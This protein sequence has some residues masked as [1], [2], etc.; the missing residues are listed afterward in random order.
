MHDPGNTCTLISIYI[1]H[2][3]MTHKKCTGSTQDQIKLIIRRDKYKKSQKQGG[4]CINKTVLGE[5]GTE[6]CGICIRRRLPFPS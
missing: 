5:L 2:Y 3:F 1:C 6:L 4:R